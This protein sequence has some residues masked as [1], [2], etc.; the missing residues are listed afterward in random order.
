[1][2]FLTLLFALL[3]AALPARGEPA[4][5]LAALAQIP[6]DPDW[7]G[8]TRTVDI[9][10]L[11]ALRQVSGVGSDVTLTA[12][13]EHR[14]SPADELAATSLLWRL[15]GTVGFRDYLLAG[16]AL[17]PEQLGLD[18]LELGWFS[19]P[20]TP[21]R[22]LL[23]LG[24]EALPRDAALAVLGQAGFMPVEHDGITAW[25]KGE[26]DFGQD[27]RNRAPGFPFWGW[28]GMSARL[29]R[30]EAALVGARSWA[31]LDLA[32]AVE[33]GEAESLADLPR[34]RLAAEALAHADY[35]AG[36]VLQVTFL[37]QA[38]G[39]GVLAAAPDGLPPFELFAF[40]DR[41][42]A[43]GQQ[44]VLVLSYGTDAATAAAAA[45]A[46]AE[47]L[48]QYK[49][50]KGATLAERFP[51]LTV[52]P[53]LL[54]SKTGAAAV[55]RLATPPEPAK[56][57]SGKVNNRSRLYAHFLRMLYSRDLGFLAPRG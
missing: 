42:D 32:L 2:R 18:F 44:V 41:E 24:G 8:K 39:E 12:F 6:A 52:E 15:H 31:D 28:L 47:R 48:T 25:A 5:I 43:S 56:S 19:E 27:L 54:E 37:D 38:H 55:V 21:P 34:F 1:M 16:A 13:A 3:L 45:D 35:S 50:S 53:T 46:L 33:R 30:G 14:L 20:G 10:D 29:F 51:G 40:A 36:P 23:L 49:D 9:V 26:K 7:W 22:V 57:E 17:W 4:T 11:A